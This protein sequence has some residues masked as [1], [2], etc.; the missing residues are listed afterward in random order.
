MRPHVVLAPGIVMVGA[1]FT[2]LALAAPPS[3]PPGAPGGPA[4]SARPHAE[5]KPSPRPG[6]EHHGPHGEHGEDHPGKPMGS[7]FPAPSGSAFG[8]LGRDHAEGDGGALRD[9]KDRAQ[10]HRRRLKMRF[11]RMFRNGG[12]PPGFAEEMKRHARR[13]ARLERAHDVAQ[14]AKDADAIALAE[15]LLAKENQRHERWLTAHA[16]AA[17]GSAAA[18]MPAPEGSAP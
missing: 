1:L 3:G 15:K 10:S 14:K 11:H 4:G 2:A 16:P 9:S 8:H 18:P 17:V 7:A 6:D 12:P 13:V 5:G